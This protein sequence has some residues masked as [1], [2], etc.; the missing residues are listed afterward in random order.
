MNEKIK[1]L[2]EAIKMQDGIMVESQAQIRQAQ[3]ILENM[4]MQYKRA[5]EKKLHLQEK[6][7]EELIK[8]KEAENQLQKKKLEIVKK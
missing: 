8:Q 5:M 7:I 2:E 4:N 6:M 3:A 1:S